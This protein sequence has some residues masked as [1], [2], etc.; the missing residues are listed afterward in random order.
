M[1]Y[2]LAAAQNFIMNGKVIVVTGA[3][4]ALGKVVADVGAG[5]GRAR[6][7]KHRSRPRPQI[8]A[9]E[10]RIDIGGVDLTDAAEAGRPST[11]S[12]STISAP[13]TR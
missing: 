4:G 2:R 1:V 7:Q 13:F 12:A 9:T 3:S 11:P 10:N 6:Y 5:A 8:A